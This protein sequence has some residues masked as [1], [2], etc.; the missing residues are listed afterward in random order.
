MKR[1]MKRKAMKAPAVEA[2]I[3]V[4]VEGER[5]EEEGWGVAVGIGVGEDVDEALV[6]D[7]EVS[8]DRTDVLEVEKLVVEL[9]VVELLVDDVE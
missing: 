7:R 1:R 6:G 5:P 4:L 3:A 9:L 2:I 8:E